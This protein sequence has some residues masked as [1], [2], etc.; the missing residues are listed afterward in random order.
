MDALRG[1]YATL[2]LG[3]G[4]SARDVRRQFKRLAR[5]WHPDRFARDPQGQAEAAARMR[6]I[7]AAY[8]LIQS[9]DSPAVSPVPELGD[10]SKAPNEP[11]ETVTTPLSRDAIDGIVRSIGTEG[12]FD[13]L[14]RFMFWSWPLILALFIDPPGHQWLEDEIARR[15]HSWVRLWQALL[16]ALAVLLRL[17]QRRTRR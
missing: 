11:R 2:E 4:A 12:N 3:P 7:N 14:A 10:V 6:Q 17:W 16:V 13:V 9:A 15:P 8:E 5:R 1:A